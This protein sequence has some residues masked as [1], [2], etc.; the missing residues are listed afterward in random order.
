MKRRG[1]EFH[2]ES[3][4]PGSGTLVQNSRRSLRASP[5]PSSTGRP[6]LGNE[7]RRETRNFGTKI[8]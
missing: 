7:D 2:K 5:E 4:N 6:S 1:R 8:L 3:V